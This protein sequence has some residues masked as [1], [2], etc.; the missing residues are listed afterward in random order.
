MAQ[1]IA[2]EEEEE[3]EA[4]SVEPGSPDV[5][6]IGA[7]DMDTQMFLAKL[8]DPS[9]DVQDL[10]AEFAPPAP[11]PPPAPPARVAEEEE[12]GEE[13]NESP[14]ERILRSLDSDPDTVELI[15][16]I[17]ELLLSEASAL[18]DPD[19]IERPHARVGDESLFE[20]QTDYLLT[21]ASNRG[22]LE[23]PAVY[24]AADPI[25]FHEWLFDI[26]DSFYEDDCVTEAQLRL[27]RAALNAEDPV[28]PAILNLLG[29]DCDSVEL[30]TFLGESFARETVNS[31]SGYWP[32]MRLFETT[33]PASLLK[34]L[35]VIGVTAS[36]VRYIWN[37]CSVFCMT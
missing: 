3:E 8:A 13:A 16:H 17:D 2:E 12:E 22:R 31:G 32:L 15:R 30:A 11:P 21:R 28:C 4:A 23:L 14:C 29:H 5:E 25:E 18:F 10:E 26:S 20:D 7:P 37:R 1:R 6:L 35:K 27:G 33:G 19:L 24:A 36:A 34:K 9:R